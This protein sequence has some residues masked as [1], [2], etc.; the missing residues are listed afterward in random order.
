VYVDEPNGILSSE[1]K[2]KCQGSMYKG[3]KINVKYPALKIYH[4]CGND[5][6]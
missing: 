3:E 2:K 1:I 6:F 5:W 4:A